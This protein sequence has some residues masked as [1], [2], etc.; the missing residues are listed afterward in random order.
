MSFVYNDGGR[1]ETGFSGSTRDCAARAASIASERP[2]QE[3]YDLI[4]SIGENERTGK[5]KTK[6]SNA[7]TGV[8]RYTMDRLMSQLGFIWVPTMKIGQGCK[9][10]LRSDELPNGRLVCLVSRHYVAVID[11]T[12]HDTYDS[13]RGGT[14][15]VYGYWKKV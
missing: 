12:I 5:R 4:N 6:K 7:R 8:F 15:C 3:V 10:H 2:Y 14:R 9:V 13:T 11:G 1:K